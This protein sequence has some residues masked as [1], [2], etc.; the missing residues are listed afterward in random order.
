MPKTNAGLAG[1]LTAPLCCRYLL[2]VF[3]DTHIAVGQGEDACNQ[4]LRWG[5]G[6]LLDGQLE[7]LGVWQSASTDETLSAR[8]SEDLQLRGVEEIRFV[9]GL[10]SPGFERAQDALCLG[11]EALPSSSHL[12]LQIGTKLRAQDREAG[13]DFSASLFSASTAERAGAAL[14][15]FAASPVGVKCPELV[16][17]WRLAIQQLSPF[18][19]SAPRIRRVVRNAD[20]AAMQLS[21]AMRRAVNRHGCFYSLEAATSLVAET[22]IRAEARLSA[23]AAS[24]ATGPRYRGAGVSAR[25]GVSAAGL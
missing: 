15:K 14:A 7:L 12:S 16:E 25:S 21:R 1:L 13:S 17:G 24:P 23:R 5:L 8:I 11:A 9:A 22:L 6:T 2:A 4:V 18:Y 10:Q 3:D 20:A 19:A